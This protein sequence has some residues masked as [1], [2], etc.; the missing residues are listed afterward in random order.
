[1]YN[2]NITFVPQQLAMKIILFFILS[3]FWLTAPAQKK[4]ASAIAADYKNNNAG[5]SRPKLVVG[6][7]IDQMR[8]DYLYRF[9][10]LFK[11]DGGFKRLMNEGFTCE[12]T[13]V[14]YTPT[15][16]AAGHTCVYTGSVPAIHGMVGN[17]W[18]DRL[19]NKTVYCTDDDSASSVGSTDDA[20][21]MS[22]RNMFTTTVGDELKLATN[23]KSKVIGIAI[24]D[25]GAILPAGHAADAA[26]WYDPKNGNFISSSYYMQSLPKWAQD[27]NKKKLADSLYKLNWNTI[28]PAATY[29][30]YS[31]PDD[32]P[33]E[34]KPFGTGKAAFPYDLSKYIGTDYSKIASTPYGNT[35]TAAIAEAAVAG[36]GLGKGSTTDFLA[37]SFSS[38]DYIGHAFGPDSWEQLDDYVRLDKV[39]GD[40]FNFLDAQVGKGNYTL[41]LTAD[42]AVAHVPNFSVAHKLPGGAYPGSGIV[43]KLKAILKTKYGIEGLIQAEEN[44]QLYLS[45]R[46][47]DSAGIDRQQLN[48][49]IINFLLQQDGIV[50]AFALSDLMTI[51]LNSKQRD[52]FANGYLPMRSGDIQLVLKPGYVS[53]SGNGTSHGLWNPYD[54]HIPLLWYG[55]GVVKGK[56][57]REVYMT[58]IAA[59]VSALLHIQMPSGCVGKVIDEAL[60]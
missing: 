42:H 55:W 24:K 39:L 31:A 4:N 15:V 10:N 23:F 12:N 13:F 25:R 49:V 17:E 2:A 50:N 18:Y 41:F 40:F 57:R 56:S 51:P 45:Q 11:Q 5:I 14:P 8:P 43:S 54:A 37:V 35:L 9:Y 20:G 36:E 26:F 22:P 59:T 38:P 1:M 53:G 34:N 21:K 3:I 29:L 16:T 30:Q 28:L 33:Y 58:D 7:V 19:L 48:R 27:F 60:K 32:E 6:I 44:S 47:I 52:M 46:L